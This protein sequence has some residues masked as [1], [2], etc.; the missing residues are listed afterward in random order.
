MRLSGMP[1]LGFTLI[2]LLI[3]VAILGLLLV[4]GVPNYIVW[5]SDSQISNTAESVS[6]GLRTAQAQAINLNQPVRFVLNPTKATGGWT[7]QLDN[8]PNTVLRTATFAEGTD[9]VTITPL[10]AGT[11]TV[12]Y[13]GLGRVTANADATAPLYKIRLTIAAV[14]GSKELDVVLGDAAQ[15][16]NSIK[17]CDP[18]WALPDPKACPT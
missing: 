16:F 12:T 6:A 14:A 13:T 9:Q 18:S 1:S 8:P 7:V 3:S 5:L 2:E 17:V 11:T 15:S 4:L 10:P